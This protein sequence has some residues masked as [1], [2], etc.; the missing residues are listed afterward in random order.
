MNACPVLSPN[1]SH[2]LHCDDQHPWKGIPQSEDIL[3]ILC[4][5][6]F[7]PCLTLPLTTFSFTQHLYMLL[8]LISHRYSNSLRSPFEVLHSFSHTRCYPYEEHLNERADR[9]CTLR[10]VIAQFR[11]LQTLK[12]AASGMYLLRTRQLIQAIFSHPNLMA[13]SHCLCTDFFFP[14]KHPL[15]L[16]S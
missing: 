12:I 3:S 8:E 14:G 4:I 9:L 2:P 11:A 10:V 6:K 15:M 7:Q 13:I 1:L 5:I 16:L